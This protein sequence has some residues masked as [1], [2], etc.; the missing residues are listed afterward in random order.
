[1][2]ATAFDFR[3]LWLWIDTLNAAALLATGEDIPIGIGTVFG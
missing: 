3:Q 1:V 2:R